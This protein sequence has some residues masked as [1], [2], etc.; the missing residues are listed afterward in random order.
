MYYVAPH[1]L[2]RDFPEMQEQMK[3]L[4]QNDATFARLIQ[5]YEDLDKRISGVESGTENM[6]DLQLQA[7]KHERVT[8]KDTIADKLKA[9]AAN[10]S[11]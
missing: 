9:A 1:S 3:L 10:D 2:T 11:R 4:R 6:D 7:L 5:D 8:M